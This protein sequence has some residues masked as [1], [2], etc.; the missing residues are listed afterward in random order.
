MFALYGPA[1]SLLH[2]LAFGDASADLGPFIYAF[3]L[4]FPYL[5]LSAPFAFLVGFSL[6]MMVRA[7]KQRLL[8]EL[9]AGAVTWS[10]L[11]LIYFIVCLVAPPFADID[12]SMSARAVWVSTLGFVAFQALIGALAGAVFGA[13]R[14]LFAK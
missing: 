14:I 2:R 3:G 7:G 10:A 9:I 1:T 11:S 8:T 13:G 4:T 6:V 5:A 12:A